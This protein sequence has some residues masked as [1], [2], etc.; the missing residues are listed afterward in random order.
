MRSQEQRGRPRRTRHM[1][2]NLQVSGHWSGGGGR[3]Q[4][5]QRPESHASLDRGPSRGCGGPGGGEQGRV[6][7]GR[8]ALPREPPT[9]R[10][11]LS[12]A[13]FLEE[14]ATGGSCAAHDAVA[15]VGDS[16]VP[17][18]GRLPEWAALWPEQH[19]GPP[20]SRVHS[21]DAARV[22]EHTLA[23]V[24]GGRAEVRVCG[25]AHAQRP[26]KGRHS[27]PQGP[28]NFLKMFSW[29]AQAWRRSW[30]SLG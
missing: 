23:G 25:Q 26:H 21:A 19:L 4:G 8:A 7:T 14:D 15:V 9:S 2:L 12:R 17:T 29:R 5:G 30:H 27:S 13:H 11:A 22:A 6:S 28:S 1:A 3:G 20:C 18:H 16:I 10:M 24:W